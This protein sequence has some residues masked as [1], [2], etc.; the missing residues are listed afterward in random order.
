MP[1]SSVSDVEATILSPVAQAARQRYLGLYRRRVALIAA[2]AI[3]MIILAAWGAT[4]GASGLGV[5]EI[6]ASVLASAGLPLAEGMT[7]REVSVVLELRLPRV[8]LALLGGAALGLSGAVMQGVTRNML[9]SPYTLGISA[10]AAFGASLVIF[11]SPVLPHPA[12]VVASAFAFALACALVVFGSGLRPGTSPETIILI[13]IALM[14]LFTAGTA[15]LQFLASDEQ[16]AAVVHWTFGSL[17]RATWSAVLAIVAATIISWPI[18]ALHAGELDAIASGGD[19]YARSLGVAVERTRFVLCIAAVL[20]TSTVISFTGVIGF[21]GLV[22]AHMARLLVGG[23]H[24][25]LLPLSA[26]VGAT[27]LVGADALGR[28]AF[29]PTA[30]PVGITV[31]YLGVPIFL[32]LIARGSGRQQ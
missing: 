23:D 17:N 31:A 11:F 32:H 8:V 26:I 4:I 18:L 16:L 10:A 7:A 30:L 12:L 15:T 1:P 6:V 5:A 2:G 25:L 27:L 19:E 24:R 29:S 14:Y 28:V 9:V 21:V 13:G 22:A 20:L 3:G